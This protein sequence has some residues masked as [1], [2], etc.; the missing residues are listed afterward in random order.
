MRAKNALAVPKSSQLVT[1]LAEK[2]EKLQ[3]RTAHTRRAE[4]PMQ[5]SVFLQEAGT[6]HQLK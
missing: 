6:K 1:L 3:I 2:N 5:K 4:D